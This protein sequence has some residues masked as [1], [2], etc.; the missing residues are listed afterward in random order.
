MTHEQYG[1][2]IHGRSNHGNTDV[3]LRQMYENLAREEQ[4]L[5]GTRGLQP[6]SDQQ[7]FEVFLPKSLRT[8][9]NK[10]LFDVWKA[11]SPLKYGVT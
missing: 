4:D 10:V 1:Y 6:H 8:T 7:T 9:Y 3:G 2:Y 5:C 11:V